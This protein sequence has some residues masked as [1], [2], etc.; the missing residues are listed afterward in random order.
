[1]LRSGAQVAVLG[2]PPTSP[3]VDCAAR[4]SGADCS[5]VSDTAAD[6]ESSHLNA[7]LRRAV[8]GLPGHAAFVS[9]SDEVCGTRGRCRIA[10]G[11]TLVRFDGVHYTAGYSRMIAPVI[12]DRMRRAGIALPAVAGAGS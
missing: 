2:I 4:H 10:D 12:V 3:P 6:P 1:M 5:D 8:A 9:V 11:S 7:L